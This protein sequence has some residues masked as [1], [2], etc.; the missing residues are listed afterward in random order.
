[1]AFT[2]D[3]MDSLSR[4]LLIPI[5]LVLD[6]GMF[7]YLVMAYHSRRQESRVRLLLLASFL[8]FATQVY[9]HESNE[10]ALALND[11]SES[12]LQLTFLTQISLIG[13]G[14][15]FKVQLRSIL[16][17]TY[18]AEAL[19]VLGWI[20]VVCTVLEAANVI[21]GDM[22]HLLGNVLET[23]SLLYVLVF[24]FYYLTLTHGFYNALAERKLDILL[25]VVLV[26]HEFPFMILDHKTGL[27]W[28]FVQGIFNR[29]VIVACIIHNDKQKAH[30][31]GG[32]SY[33]AKTKKYSITAS[34]PTRLVSLTIQGPISNLIPDVVAPRS[35]SFTVYQLPSGITKTT[36][37]PDKPT[38]I[39]HAST[40]VIDPEHI[41][42][43]FE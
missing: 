20:N 33:S 29:I 21:E 27:S 11:I 42:E 36:I 24:H 38:D 2:Q 4:S 13:H 22:F 28:E 30:S 35:G 25:Y 6:S 8:G 12:S 17:F 9:S 39:N 10:T 1:M 37:S 26:L 7:H 41:I 14:V 15:C 16:W 40:R 19:V 18:A 5:M 31:S 34:I 23:V 43:T 3:G 32:S